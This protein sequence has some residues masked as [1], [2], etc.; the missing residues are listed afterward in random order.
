MQC[1]SCRFVV[2]EACEVDGFQLSLK[3]ELDQEPDSSLH[4]AEVSGLPC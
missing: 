2:A 1:R 3:I 4:T